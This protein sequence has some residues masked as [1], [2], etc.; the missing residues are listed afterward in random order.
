MDKEVQT[1]EYKVDAIVDL[2]MS[3]DSEERPK[4]KSLLKQSLAYG[5]KRRATYQDG[6][7]KQKKNTAEKYNRT[8]SY[9]ATAREISEELGFMVSESNVRRWADEYLTE[10][11]L[12]H[13]TK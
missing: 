5:K 6:F 10:D 7:N 2:L 3:L 4:A 13:V 8:G 12:K 9:A 11:E 1:E